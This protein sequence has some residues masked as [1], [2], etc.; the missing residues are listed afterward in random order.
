MEEEKIQFVPNLINGL[1]VTCIM[2]TYGLA[3]VKVAGTVQVL[4]PGL[5]LPG[6]VFE[7]LFGI[8]KDATAADNFKIKFSMLRLRA[9][10]N[11]LEYYELSK[12]ITNTPV[13]IEDVTE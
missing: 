11:Q 8:M 12:A 13:V 9:A 7:Q 4:K 2:D 1:G 10:V 5:S 6:G 3:R